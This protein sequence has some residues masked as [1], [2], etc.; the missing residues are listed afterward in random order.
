MPQ[1]FYIDES[2]LDGQLKK[3]DENLW[4][5]LDFAYLHEDMTIT[6]ESLMGEWFQ[7]AFP[8]RYE[9][10]T[11][12]YNNL[13]E[14]EKEFYD[15]IDEWLMDF[16]RWWMEE[17]ENLDNDNKKLFIERY[18]LTIASGLHSDTYNEET[19]MEEINDSWKYIIGE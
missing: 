15:D 11:E 5:M 13:E 4:G 10:L 6:I 2:D 17:F 9:S 14:S 16:G 12:E 7:E 18:R 3:L 1:R 8:D 19:L